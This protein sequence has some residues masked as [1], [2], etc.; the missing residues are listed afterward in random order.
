MFDVD[1]T[2]FSSGFRLIKQAD[3]EA[4]LAAEVYMFDTLAGG[5]G[6]SARAGESMDELLR[7][8]VVEVLSCD[9]EV[10][11]GCDRSCYRCLRHYHNQVYHTRLDRRLARDLLSHLLDGKRPADGDVDCQE[12]AL[13]GLG[14]TLELDGID[15]HTGVTMGGVK[16]PMVAEHAGQRVALCV[17][18]ALVT[19]QCREGLV[20]KLDAA[21][22]LVRPLNA[23]Q[24]DRN[25]PA[26]HLG[27]RKCLGLPYS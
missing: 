3:K 6:Y 10:G 8:Y 11:A 16:V 17:T 12:K 18:H 15:V 26:C 2:E 13:R 25:L 24:L 14:A 5:A 21:G 1:F 9:D 27:V 7:K 4:P 20:D 19:E 22:L 23:Y